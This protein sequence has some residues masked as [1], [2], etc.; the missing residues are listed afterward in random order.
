MELVYIVF[1]IFTGMVI[2]FFRWYRPMKQQIK[3]L[4]EGI[5]D[6]IKSG[7][8]GT[9]KGSTNSEIDLNK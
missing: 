9:I 7:L 3:D 6:C 5:H 4:Q 8:V 1:G 2:T